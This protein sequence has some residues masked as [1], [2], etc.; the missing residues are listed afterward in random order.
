MPT[1]KTEVTPAEIEARIREAEQ[2]LAATEAR[3]GEAALEAISDPA[4]KTLVKLDAEA[5][6]LRTKLS[7]LKSAYGVA[8]DRAARKAA[9]ARFEQRL[10]ELAEFEAFAQHKN[11]AVA[12]FCAA[13]EAASSAYREINDFS[14]QMQNWTPSGVSWPSGM[15]AHIGDVLVNGVAQPAGH[16]SLAASE[17]WKAAGIDRIGQGGALPGS[18]ALSF[19]GLLDSDAVESWADSAPRLNSYIAQHLKRQIEDIRQFELEAIDGNIED[20][21]A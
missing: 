17:M 18:K 1:P 12:K 4:N 20:A 5:G 3:R 16:E 2:A 19:S 21:A 10:K 13:I 7:T 9:E 8:W 6:E 14:S 11:A 15:T